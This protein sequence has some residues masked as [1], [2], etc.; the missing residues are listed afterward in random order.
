MERWYLGWSLFEIPSQGW[1]SVWCWALRSSWELLTH[2]FAV[3][4]YSQSSLALF[5]EYGP[6]IMRAGDFPTP[7]KQTMDIRWWN[8]LK[9]KK[10]A[11]LVQTSWKVSSEYQC[12]TS[13]WSPWSRECAGGPG[14]NETPSLIITRA[15]SRPLA[16]DWSQTGPG[17]RAR[18]WLRRRLFPH[19]TYRN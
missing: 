9:F 11:Y 6:W 7:K 18:T 3:G 4:W 1:V 2:F 16:P 14:P 10:W 15:R 8:K 19:Q 5:L 17:P 12:V 13:S